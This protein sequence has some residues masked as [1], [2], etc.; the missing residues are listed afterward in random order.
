MFSK[1]QQLIEERT[2]D[3]QAAVRDMEEG[4]G[5][6]LARQTQWTPVRSGGTKGWARRLVQSGSD[7]LTFRPTKRKLLFCAVP[8]LVGVYII[9]FQPIQ[10]SGPSWSQ[11]VVGLVFLAM[12][13]MIGYR[14]C[15]PVV[16]DKR[17]GACWTGWRAPASAEAARD[18]DGGAALGDVR[19]V[20]VIPERLRNT[21]SKFSYEV[22]LVLADSNRINLVDHSRRSVIRE[23]AQTLGRFLDVPVWDAS[24]LPPGVTPAS[25]SGGD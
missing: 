8:V 2:Q 15:T 21:E 10:N 19:A 23:D 7:R 18:Q 12:G 1:I 13:L 16:V 24:S 4:F 14:L 17:L 22:N 3:A 25:R 20:Q 5:D 9:V 6:P 11:S